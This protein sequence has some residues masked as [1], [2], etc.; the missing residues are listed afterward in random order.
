MI[1]SELIEEKWKAQRKMAAE[2]NYD[3]KKMLD[4]AEKIVDQMIK[5][6]GVTLKYA[7]MKPSFDREKMVEI[8][9]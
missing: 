2:A 7:K 3:I 8:R 9:R 6:H 4:N 1:V 5:E